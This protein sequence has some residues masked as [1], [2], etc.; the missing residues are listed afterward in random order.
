MIGVFE[1]VHK[2]WNQAASQQQP[3]REKSST[4]IVSLIASRLQ[5]EADLGASDRALLTRTTQTR[6]T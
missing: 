5:F 1:V 4:T 3:A 6:S 2:E